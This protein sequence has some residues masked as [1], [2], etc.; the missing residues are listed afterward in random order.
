VGADHALSFPRLSAL[1]DQIVAFLDAAVV[2]RVPGHEA[3]PVAGLAPGEAAPAGSSTF[4]PGACGNILQVKDTL[5]ACLRYFRRMEPSSPAVL[6]IGQAQQLI[7]K[8]LIEVIQ[9]MFPEHLE[10]AVFE[11]GDRTRFRLP[12][13]RLGAPEEPAGDDGYEEPSYDTSEEDTFEE[14]GSEALGEDDGETAEAA[15]PALYVASRAD[16]VTGM[17]AVAAFYRRVEPSHPTPLLMD[18]A[19]ALAQQD[20]LALLGSILP[21]VAAMPEA[22]N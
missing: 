11:I 13:E 8:S 18:K 5:A 10:K 9:I 16:A 22:E 20:F 3:L 19:C 1:V 17:R 2:R 15:P 6:L 14:A 4:A 12:L 7:G 21:E